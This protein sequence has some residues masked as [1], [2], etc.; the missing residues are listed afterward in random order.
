M[1]MVTREYKVYEY[2][3]LSEDAKEKVRQNIGN[4]DCEVFLSDTLNES[5]KDLLNQFAFP[6]EDNVIKYSLSNCQGDG[7]SFYFEESLTYEIIDIIKRVNLEDDFKN[8]STRSK[9]YVSKV[10]NQI[11][12]SDL[13]MKRLEF[14]IEEGIFSISVANNN[15]IN[16]CHKFSVDRDFEL[17]STYEWFPKWSEFEEL[18]ERVFNFIKNLTLNLCDMMENIGY[19]EIEYRYSDENAKNASE[20]NEY[21]YLEDGTLFE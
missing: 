20:I 17:D 10:T 21:F 13:E 1:K 3:E 8:F 18:V 2:N 9:E 4:E 6:S 14:M 11:S 19:E 16:Y 7:V 12:I 5:F 15:Y